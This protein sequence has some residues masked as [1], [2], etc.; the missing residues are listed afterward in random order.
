MLSPSPWRLT[1]IL[2]VVGSSLI[3]CRSSKMSQEVSASN[4]GRHE[5]GAMSPEVATDTPSGESLALVGP[6]ESLTQWERLLPNEEET[7]TKVGQELIAQINNDYV[8][9]GKRAFRD[10][11]PRGIAC[12]AATFTVTADLPEAYQ[13]GVFATPGQSFDAIIRFSSSLG[14]AGDDTRDARGMAVKL[15]GVPGKKLL[16]D[17]PDATTHD[18][19]MINF[20]TFPARDAVEFAGIVSMKTNP[21]NAAKFLKENP[22]L[23]ARELKELAQATTGNPDNGKSLAAHTFFSQVPY[24]LKG[25]AVNA[26]VKYIARPCDKVP[27][28]SFLDGSD[29][30]LRND[31]QKRLSRGELCWQFGAQIHAKAQVS[32]VEDGMKLWKESDIPFTKLAEIRIPKQLF[33]TDE[34][35]HYCDALSMQPWHALPEHRPLGNLNRTRKIVYETISDYRH[36]QNDESALRKEPTDRSTWDSFTSTTYREWNTIKVPA[37]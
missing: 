13:T 36:E 10:A 24:L 15:F 31:L 7:A 21:L 37:R 17:Q 12:V 9:K 33:R 16:N 4:S 28:S 27:L 26:P 5:V 30:E 8:K 29:G 14:P 25:P 18:F 1:L 2:S 34:K 20:P 32:D 22:L 6:A 19:L 35:L 23:R 3:A 11:H